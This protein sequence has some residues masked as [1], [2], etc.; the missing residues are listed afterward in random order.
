MDRGSG[1]W[2]LDGLESISRDVAMIRGCRGRGEGVVAGDGAWFVRGEGVVVVG[3][4]AWFVRGEGV[5]V[6]GVD[7]WF[8]RGEGVVVAGPPCSNHARSSADRSL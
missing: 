2:L 6:V 4:D 5:V 1:R 8:V 7:A 3:V